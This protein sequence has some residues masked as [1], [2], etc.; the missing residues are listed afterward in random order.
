MRRRWTLTEDRS[1]EARYLSDQLK[2]HPLVA[3]VLANRGV[4]ELAAVKKFLNRF[5]DGMHDP[6]LMPGLPEAATRIHDAITAGRKICIYGDY[7]VD[8]M[9]GSSIL[10]EVLRIAGTTR[11][12]TYPI[13]LKKVMA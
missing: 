12:I 1:G 5:L 6:S 3:R 2:L 8:G 7:D 10:L 13:G 9:C 11:A 4:T